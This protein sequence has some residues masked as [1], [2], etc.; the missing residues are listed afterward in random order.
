MKPTDFDIYEV[1]IACEC[2]GIMRDALIA[3]GVRAFSCDLK[4]TQRPGPHYQGDV[5]DVLY[6]PR[7]G[8]IAHPVCKY[9]TNAGA[10]HL[11][12][13][14]NGKWAKEHGPDEDRWRL[15]REGAE[16]FKMFDR[17]EHIPF[18][19][20][21]NP[22]MHG[23]AS[24]IIGRRATQYVQ[25]WMFG[26]PFS[27]ATGFHLTKLPPLVS[28]RGKSWYINRGIKIEQAAWMMGPSEDREE[29]RS[30]TYP[31]IARAAAKQWGPIFLR[32]AE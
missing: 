16:F 24:K 10:K 25:P 22:I 14:I 2:S 18:R 27:K 8:L 32:E 1:L 20:V 29:R 31:G 17:A 28:E 30:E 3:V 11:Y 12:K 4:P 9:L 23:H 15:M 19:A 26:D 5:R 7:T 21:E 6:R 13:R